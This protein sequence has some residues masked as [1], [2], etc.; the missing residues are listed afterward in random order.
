MSFIGRI[1]AATAGFTDERVRLAGEAIA[2]SLAVKMLGERCA[3]PNTWARTAQSQMCLQCVA[4]CCGIGIAVAARAARRVHEVH[5][6]KGHSYAFALFSA[7]HQK[8]RLQCPA[9]FCSANT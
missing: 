5:S 4:P 6:H 1:R 3:L 9:S 2:G 8:L 7:G